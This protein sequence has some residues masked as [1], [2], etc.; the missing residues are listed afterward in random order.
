[1]IGNDRRFRARSKS[2]P[3]EREG[4]K[5]RFGDEVKSPANGLL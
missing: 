4:R 5:A 3:G 1:M 2:M